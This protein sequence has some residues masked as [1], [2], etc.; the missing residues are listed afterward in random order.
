MDAFTHKLAARSA[1]SPAGSA[2]PRPHQM[3][4]EME[5]P[6]F[7][8]I[9]GISATIVGT[10]LAILAVPFNPQKEGSLFLSGVIMSLGLAAAPVM[11]FFEN[12]RNILRAENIVGMAPIYWLCLDL[13]TSIYDM[14]AVTDAAVRKAFLSVGIFTVMFWLG[15]MRKP[16]KLPKA[17][18]KSCS[19]RPDVWTI[20]PVATLCFVIAMGTFAIPC[21]GDFG[22][23]FRSL[24]ENRWAAPWSRSE[25]G[26]WSAFIDHLSYFGYLLPTF[27]VMLMRRKGFWHLATLLV[28]AMAGVYLIFVMHGGAR[29][30]VGVMLGAA[31]TFWI[32]DRERVQLWHLMVAACI[33]A[34]ILWIMQAMLVVRSVG[35]GTI[36]LGN[37]GKIALLTLQGDQAID[38]APKGLAVDDNFYRLVQLHSLI[39]EQHPFVYWRQLYYVICRPIP[40]V[41]W[42]GKPVDGGFNLGALDNKGASLSTTI[43]GEMWM[44]W[45][46]F[47]VIL[48]GWVFGRVSRMGEPLFNVARGSMGP[49]FYGYLT[50]I[51]AVGYRSMVELLLFSYALLAW[52]GA[53]WMYSKIRGR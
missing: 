29:R 27:A 40:R 33:T 43:V 39:P 14:P 23:M 45:G 48:G 7:F 46:Y 25:I 11:A 3:S 22:L 34:V 6:G 36:G 4:A 9:L 31:L 44:S 10:L 50:L 49:M 28:F 42:E 19:F 21:R 5:A 16:W 32:L 35:I 30:I 18:L 15:T 20:L 1:G 51:G 52:V 8:P 37:A 24:Q 26:G 38:G 41:L 17:F 2:R 13:I 47:A 53:T 12:P